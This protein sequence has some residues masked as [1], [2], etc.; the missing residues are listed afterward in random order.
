MAIQSS[1]VQL[2]ARIV[3]QEMAVY[4]NDWQLDHLPERVDLLRKL[5]HSNL[6]LPNVIYTHCEVQLYLVTYSCLLL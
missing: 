5:L 2:I 1:T 4:L 3:M 6:S